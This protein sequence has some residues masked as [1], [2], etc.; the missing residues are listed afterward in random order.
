MLPGNGKSCSFICLSALYPE[1]SPHHDAFALPRAAA[2][3]IVVDVNFRLSLTEASEWLVLVYNS[4][5]RGAC[6]NQL[7]N[8]GHESTAEYKS[9]GHLEMDCF[10]L[11]KQGSERGSTE[12]KTPPQSLLHHRFICLFPLSTAK[13][14]KGECDAKSLLTQLMIR[15]DAYG[16]L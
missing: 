14:K 15:H 16:L 6:S 12:A 7:R 2:F 9:R 5:A 10:S 1:C 3:D 4:P 11:Y 8:M 13:K